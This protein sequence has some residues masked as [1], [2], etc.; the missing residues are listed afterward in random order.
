MFVLFH[1][2]WT[3]FAANSHE[4]DGDLYQQDRQ[5]KNKKNGEFVKS[6]FFFA[7]SL[8]L[9]LSRLSFSFI[10]PRHESTRATIHH[11][12]QLSLDKVLSLFQFQ[13]GWLKVVTRWLAKFKSAHQLKWHRFS[14]FRWKNI[15]EMTVLKKTVQKLT[16]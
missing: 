11:I 14:S 8:S 12:L 15:L 7:F 10:Q 9:S 5:Y 2:T 13:S 3:V 16:N 1:L 4:I 6:D